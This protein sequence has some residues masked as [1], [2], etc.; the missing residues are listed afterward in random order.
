MNSDDEEA[1]DDAEIVQLPHR[2][3]RIIVCDLGK[4]LYGKV[5]LCL[6]NVFDK[7]GN[8]LFVYLCETMIGSNQFL[9]TLNR[10]LIFDPLSL[11]DEYYNHANCDN[12]LLIHYGQ[13]RGKEWLDMFGDYLRNC[14]EATLNDITYFNRRCTSPLLAIVASSPPPKSTE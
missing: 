2:S 13:T 5:R 11:W 6:P 7:Q 14:P 3:M 9:K 8:D 10:F 12:S 1:R 4:S